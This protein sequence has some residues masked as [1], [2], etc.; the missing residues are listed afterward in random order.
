VQKPDPS[1]NIATPEDKISIN[2]NKDFDDQINEATT[3][4]DIE[5]REIEI[6]NNKIEGLDLLQEF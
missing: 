4:Y 6:V 3:D 5:R 1:T 2:E